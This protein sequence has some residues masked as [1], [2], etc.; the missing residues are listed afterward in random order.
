M[1]VLSW[2]QWCHN[3]HI[4]ILVSPR[5]VMDTVVMT[6]LHEEGWIT[7]AR[8]N[9][10][11]IPHTTGIW[12]Q[13]EYIANCHSEWWL[14]IKSPSTSQ[15]CRTIALQHNPSKHISAG[16]RIKEDCVTCYE[17]CFQ[18][19]RKSYQYVWSSLP[20]QLGML[21]YWKKNTWLEYCNNFI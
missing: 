6:D 1:Q 9:I 21:S 17:I 7:N 13:D 16:H 11:S 19:D 15:L 10:A 5:F 14:F 4:V 2:F 8:S 20:P 3:A 12:R 18:V